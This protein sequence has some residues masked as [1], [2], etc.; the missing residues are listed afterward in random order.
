MSLVT[1]GDIMFLK[2]KGEFEVYNIERNKFEIVEIVGLEL[3]IFF[4]WVVLYV[5]SLF[6][7][8]LKHIQKF[9]KLIAPVPKKDYECDFERV[10]RT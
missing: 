5:E 6:S 2:Y 8:K 9:K 3:S 7:P 4:Y 1:N 10:N